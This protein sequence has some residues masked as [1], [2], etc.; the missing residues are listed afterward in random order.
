MWVIDVRL[1]PQPAV[2]VVASLAASTTATTTARPQDPHIWERFGRR[3]R[4]SA[5]F[6][7]ADRNLLYAVTGEDVLTLPVPQLSPFAAQILLD[8][9][10]GRLRSGR[11]VTASYLLGTGSTLE[12]NGAKNPFSGALL[13][14]ALSYLQTQQTGR[15]DIVL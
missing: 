10:S 5:G 13:Q 9:Q 6:S 3:S 14:R 11:E 1:P 15:V 12:Q 7:S 8:R 4:A 2:P